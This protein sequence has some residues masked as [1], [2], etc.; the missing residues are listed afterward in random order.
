MLISTRRTDGGKRMF[1]ALGVP[2]PARGFLFDL[3]GVLT[4]LAGLLDRS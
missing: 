4:R 2:D 3:D 1:G